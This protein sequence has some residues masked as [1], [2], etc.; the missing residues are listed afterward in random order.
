MSNVVLVIFWISVVTVVYIYV[1]FP[2]LLA[3]RARLFAKP[4]NKARI[5]PQISLIIA[6]YNEEEVIA[7][8]MENIL[9]LDYP[10]D[11][12]EIIVASD[13]SDDKTVEV[14]K[15]YSDQG[16]I[17]VLDLPRQ[18]KNQTL[19]TAVSH[20]TGEV[21]VF[22]DADA[23]LKSDALQKLVAP[24]NDPTV[25]GV[26]GDF[27]YTS[28]D[29]NND[30]ER[31]YWGFDR[32]VKIW[33]S[34]VHSMNGITGQIFSIRRELFKEIPLDTT[35]DFFISSQAPSAHL[36]MIF[37]PA[38]VATGTLTEG[39]KEF[40]RKIRIAVRGMNGVRHLRHLLNPLKYGFYSIQLISH[41]VMRRTAVLPLLAGAITTPLLWNVGPF[42]R[43]V[44]I[45]Q[46]MFH[47]LGLIGFILRNHPLGRFKLFNLPYYFHMVNLA[48]FFVVIY[49]IRGKKFVV[50]TPPRPD[51][52]NAA[53]K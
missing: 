47:G 29:T 48:M 44:F 18:G 35:D 42:Y 13:G 34:S 8:K 51:L 39:S 2:I 11:K 12:L 45:F 46:L 52:S 19:N 5:T 10:A 43:A 49:L 31:T 30:G 16:K 33:E 6:A 27:R 9:S 14:L 41:K 15:P 20:A 25:G 38:A 50:W 1:G 26:A 28:D 40:R 37:E 24:L 22:S 3:I 32:Q 53:N 36:R 7:G 21:L 23:K 17:K 4:I